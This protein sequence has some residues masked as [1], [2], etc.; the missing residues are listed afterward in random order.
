MTT[1]MKSDIAK[2]HY[3]HV[4]K[5][6]YCAWIFCNKHQTTFDIK[7]VLLERDKVDTALANFNQSNSFHKGHDLGSCIADN[8][9]WFSRSSPIKSDTL[10]L[11]EVM[12]RNSTKW[13]ANTSSKWLTKRRL[14]TKRQ[15]FNIF[16]FSKCFAIFVIGFQEEKRGIYLVGTDGTKLS[17]LS[18]KTLTISFSTCKRWWGLDWEDQ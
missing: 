2:R 1:F 3:C 8:W 15:V 5:S 9:A 10:R 11:G 7:T 18:T 16:S 12:D 14:K 6:F 13:A 4:P 17:G